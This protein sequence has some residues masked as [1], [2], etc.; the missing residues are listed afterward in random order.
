MLEQCNKSN[1]FSNKNENDKD[2]ADNEYLQERSTVYSKD[3]LQMHKSKAIYSIYC[4]LNKFVVLVFVLSE[5]LIILLMI[6]ELNL[7][8]ASKSCSDMIL[9]PSKTLPFY[10]FPFCDNRIKQ[11]RENTINYSHLS[12]SNESKNKD[13]AIESESESNNNT[14]ESEA[15]NRL[16]GSKRDFLNH[17][18]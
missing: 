17:I 15:Y 10:Y 12:Y 18:N 9:Y 16:F 6:S 5:Y 8:D 13:D 1:H 11:I 3:P 2:D 14:V 4:F 7:I